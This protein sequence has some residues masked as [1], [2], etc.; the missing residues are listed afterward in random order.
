MRYD[1]TYN[2]EIVTVGG[3]QIGPNT[4]QLIDVNVDPITHIARLD[5]S[6]FAPKF[7]RKPGTVLTDQFIANTNCI[8]DKHS[9]KYAASRI[10]IDATRQVFGHH[11]TTMPGFKENELYP[12][13]TISHQFNYHSGIDL[14][15]QDYRITKTYVTPTNAEL[16]QQIDIKDANAL[17]DIL[18]AEAR[19]NHQTPSFDHSLNS[20]LKLISRFFRQNGGEDIN[21]TKLFQDVTNYAAQEAHTIMRDTAFEHNV[22]LLAQIDK[23]KIKE[24]NAFLKEHDLPPVNLMQSSDSFSK[25]MNY[26][27]TSKALT[28]I[29]RENGINADCFKIG[30]DVKSQ[31]MAIWDMALLRNWLLKD[32]EDLL[33]IKLCDRLSEIQDFQSKQG[34]RP[35]YMQPARMHMRAQ[36]V[37]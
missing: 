13:I 12:A 1:V 34:I 20:K 35:A 15:D 32:D 19:L 29:K 17:R 11:A 25:K 21:P 6:W 30:I 10:G 23:T 36:K 9:K 18:S 37:A 26:C 22:Q 2:H 7:L 27:S 33:G 14:N 24:I 31:G 3:I 16:G 4:C 5:H 8:N 28:L